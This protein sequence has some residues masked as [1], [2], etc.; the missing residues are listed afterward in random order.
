M[1]DWGELV[2]KQDIEYQGYVRRRDMAMRD[3]QDPKPTPKVDD[4]GFSINY[5]YRAQRD[6]EQYVKALEFYQTWA[7]E[8]AKYGDK[9]SYDKF[10][11]A[12]NQTR[13]QAQKNIDDY[14]AYYDQKRG[15]AEREYGR[16]V[17]QQMQENPA[18]EKYARY[19]NEEFD[20]RRKQAAAYLQYT[21][22]V[23]AD[24]EYNLDHSYENGKYQEAEER[25]NAAKTARDTALQQVT[26]W[27]AATKM[28]DD[29]AEVTRMR[30]M[31][32]TF[33]S[34]PNANM[35]ATEGKA[36]FHM[37]NQQAASE[38]QDAVAAQ[39]YA[40]DMAA[41]GDMGV[42]LGLAN[43]ASTSSSINMEQ[44]GY[45]KVLEKGY[46]TPQEEATF[47]YLWMKNPKEADE[48][49]R[50]MQKLH[51]DEQ[52]QKMA[53]WAGKNEKT[54][55]LAALG[56][57]ASGFVAGA[58]YLSDP[59][60]FEEPMQFFSR[61]GKALTSG[62]AEGLTE[63]GLLNSGFL[64]GTLP[65]N[66]PVIGGKGLG[67]LYQVGV[68]MLQSY[69][70]AQMGMGGAAGAML[71]AGSAAASDYTDMM[72]KG[73]SQEEA[74]LHSACAGIAEGLF[75]EVSLDKLINMDT[76]AG[77]FKNVLTQ[78]GIEASEE[79]CTTLANTVTDEMILGSRSSRQT[80]ARELM[81]SGMSYEEAQ[82]QADR[83][84]LSDTIYD[85]L[86]GALSGAGMT[87]AQYLKVA[88]INAYNKVRSN[89]AK[90]PITNYI[91]EK[92]GEGTAKM[93]AETVAAIQKYAEDN[94]MKFSADDVETVRTW[95]DAQQ[96][97]QQAQVGQTQQAG[98][99]QEAVQLQQAAENGSPAVLAPAAQQ[100]QGTDQTAGRE[101]LA[102]AEGGQTLLGPTETNRN[103]AE[104]NASQ[105]KRQAAGQSAEASNANAEL[106]R[107]E[108]RKARKAE[109]AESQRDAAERRDVQKAARRV[110]QGAQRVIDS[111]S[112]RMEGKSLAEMETEKRSLTKQYGE[113]FGS[114]VDAAIYQQAE[115]RFAQAK[116]LPALQ[117]AHREFS[118]DVKD[119]DIR[120]AVLEAFDNRRSELQR[121][122]A[123]GQQASFRARTAF[124]GNELDLRASY[125]QN[126]KTVQA[127][128]ERF[129]DDGKKVVLS[130]GETV[131]LSQLDMDADAKDIL[132]K[133]AGM[134]L[135]N[136]ASTLFQNFKTYAA[137]NS[138]G[139]TWY[140][141]L[142]G[143]YAAYLYGREN[144]IGRGAVSARVGIDAEAAQRAYDLGREHA[145]LQAEERQKE[146]DRRREEA[147][148]RG[149]GE[150]GRQVAGATEAERREWLKKDGVSEAKRQSINGRRSII[151][152]SAIQGR[153]SELSR[154]DRLQ[155][156]YI[157]NYVSALGVDLVFV[158]ASEY[159][160]KYVG[161]Q[162]S[163]IDGKIV[164]D[165]FAGRNRTSDLQSFMLR[166]LSH[167]L[168]H[169]IEDLSPQ[170]YSE[171]KRDV[172]RV[173]GDKL[174]AD[175]FEELIDQKI[176]RSEK[177]ITRA[178]AES[179]VMAD[180]CEMMLRDSMALDRLY[181]VN[182]TLG[183]RILRW[184][185]DTIT[186]LK[187]WY[188]SNWYGEAVHEEARA[189]QGLETTLR[190][191]FQDRWDDLIVK[192]TMAYGEAGKKNTAGEGGVQF[193]VREE[194][195][196]EFDTWMAK[197]GVKQRRKD[198]GFF[199]LGTT[200]KVLVDI[201]A[202]ENSVRFF[203]SKAQ[204]ILDNHP[205]M[206][207]SVLKNAP[208]IMDDPV[209]VIKSAT[210]DDS[211]TF[212]R[213]DVTSDPSKR[214]F[215]ALSL[216]EKSSIPNI[217]DLY[218]TF[219]S[220]Y[221]R[222]NENIRDL[223]L[224]VKEDKKTG[225][226][227]KSAGEILF[228]S[229]D[230]NRTEALL[231]SLGVQF[232]SE[233]TVLGSLGIIT[234]QDGT[235]NIEGTN[236]YDWQHLTEA[237]YD[238]SG[239]RGN[240]SNPVQNSD[241]DYLDAVKRGEDL[242]VQKMVRDAANKAGFT[243]PMLYHGTD[244]FGFTSIKT[245]KDVKADGF[246]FWAA[247]KESAAGTYTRYGKTRE[248]ESEI[249]YEEEEEA[250]EERSEELDEAIAD[251]R[252]LIDRIFSEWVYGQ[253]GNAEIRSGVDNSNPDPGNGDGVY[254]LL[255]EH[256]ADAFY[257][258]SDEMS[259][260][261]EDF[262]D[263][264]ERSKEWEQIEEAIVDVESAYFAL[265]EIKRSG[266]LGGIYQLYANTDNMYVIDAK[267]AA[268]NELHP[269]G[270]PKIE[271]G[272][273][274]DVPYKTRDVAN[275][276]KDN[277]YDGVIFKNIKDNGQYGRT[278]PF[279]VYAFFNPQAQVKSA[280]P[281]TYDEDGEV[282]PLSERFNRENPD[283]RYSNR[284]A[285]LERAGVAVDTQSESASPSEVRFSERSW[286][287]SRFVQNPEAAAKAL[288]KAL[289]VSEEQAKKYIA[290]I[291]SVA[292]DIAESRTRLDYESAPW[293][294]AFKSNVDYGGTID[295]STL[296][297]KRRLLTGTFSAIQR[298][299]ANTVLT[300]DD[301]L[302]IRNMMKDAGLEV[303]CGMCYVEGSRAKMGEY[304]K[305][306]LELY[307]KYFPDN[308][309]PTMADVN[310]ADGIEWVRQTH[311]ECYEQFERFYNNGGT[312][313]EGDKRAFASQG[314]PK[315]FQARTEYKGEI[316]DAFQNESTVETKN[317]NGGLRMQ[318]F[319][320]FELVH[321]IDCMQV[322]MDMSEVGLAGQAYTKVPEFARALGKTG[323]KI[324]LSLVAEGVDSKGRLIFND[325][326]GM[327]HKTAFDIREEYSDN[328][329]TILVVYDDAQLLAAMA[330]EQID[331]IIPFHRS[332]WKK[333]QYKAMGLPATT[334]DYTYQQNEKWLNPS[335]HT[336][337]YRGREVK[338]KC[339][340]YMP[341]TYWNE[342]LSGKE[343]AENY[344]KMCA[345]DGKRPKFYKLLQNN[346][347]GSYSL[348]A[349][350][351]T[352]GYWKLLIDF[353]M[354]N[355]EGECVPQQPVRPVFEYDDVIKPM[356]DE[357]KG[358]HQQ[359]PVA[360]GIV[361]QF[362]SEYKAANPREQ[363]SERD[364][365]IPTDTELLMQATEA[366][367]ENQEQKALLR[368]FKNK[369]T[370]V[371]ALERRLEKAR[372]EVQALRDE[373]NAWKDKA[374]HNATLG[375][376]M[377]ESKNRDLQ[378]QK[379][380]SEKAL[381]GAL[382]E[383]QAVV[384]DLEKQIQRERDILAG[385][386]K[387][388]AMR[389]LL[390][391]VRENAETK[392]R[393]QKNAQIGRMR[394]QKKSAEL[395]R[396]IGNLRKDLVKRILR[397]TEASFIP[398][399]LSSA[400]V[401]VLELLD[402]SPAEGT[403]AAGKYADMSNRL[404]KLSAVY[405]KLNTEGSIV[406][407]LEYEQEIR[408]RIDELAGVLDGRNVRELT[409]GDLQQVYDITRQI[410]YTIRDA[411]KMIGRN[412]R[413]TVHELGMREIQ[414]Q[415]DIRNRK[416]G[417]NV[418]IRSGNRIGSSVM[419]DALSPM[420]AAHMIG[421]YG[422]S[423]IHG[424]FTDIEDGLGSKDRVIMD[425]NKAMQ[426]LRTG[427][428]EAA[429]MD[430]MWKKRD[431][432]VKDLDGRTVRMTAMQ[433]MQIVMSWQRE[434][435]NDKLVHMEKG[436]AVI[437]DVDAV[438]RGK[439]QKAS[440]TSQHIAVTPEVVA[441][442]ESKLTD[443]DRQYMKAA[444]DVF[445]ELLGQTNEVLYALKH[446]VN[447]GEELY[448]PFAVDGNYLQAQISDGHEFDFLMKANGATAE[449]KT[450]ASQ[451]LII[452]GLEAILNRHINEQ[453]N[454]IGL[455][456]PIRN[457]A[458]V[459]NVR[460]LGTGVEVTTLNNEITKTW[461]DKA[462]GMM[463]EAL[464]NLQ[465][466]GQ[467]GYETMIA[468]AMHGLQ[469][470]FVKA[471]LVGKISVVV[472]QAA[473]FESAGSILSQ[474]AL[475][476]ARANIIE[477][478]LAQDSKHA[479][480]VK[481][482][483]DAR[484]AELWKRRIGMSME[485]IAMNRMSNGTIRRSLQRIGAAME[486][487]AVG[488]TVRSAAQIGD[489]VNWIQR[490]D[491]AT[492][493]ALGIACEYQARM[494]GFKKGTEA[495][496]QHVTDL[497][498]KT[499]RQ[500]QPMYD[501]LHRPMLQQAKKGME[502][503]KAAMPFKTVPFQ[504]MGQ[505]TD[506]AGML[507]EAMRHGTKQDKVKAAK[508]LG[509]TVMA[510]FNSTLV[511][512]GLTAL[513]YGLQH[514]TKRYRDDDDE[515]TEESFWKQYWKDVA[516]V[517]LST[518]LP[519]G[520]SELMD[521]AER[522][523]GKQKWY[524]VI[525]VGS[526][527]LVNT[528]ITSVT[529]LSDAVDAYGAG[530]KTWEDLRKQIT[531]TAM[532]VTKFFGL[533]IANAKDIVEGTI[534][535][536]ENGFFTDAD[537]ERS[538]A[539]NV[540]RYL[541]AWGDMDSDKMNAVLGEMRQ[542]Y[543]DG[544][545]SEK[546]ADKEVMSNLRDEIRS[547]YKAGEL[548]D[549]NVRELMTGLG[550]SA[551]DVKRMLK[552]LYSKM[553]ASGDIDAGRAKMV[554]SRYIGMSDNDIYWEL[555]KWDYT[556]EHKE[557]PDAA[558]WS[559]YRNLKDSL[560]SGRH[561]QEAIDELTEHGKAFN[562]VNSEIKKTVV[563]MFQKGE[564]DEDEA[565]DLLKRYWKNKDGKAYVTPDEDTLFWTLEE[566]GY[567][568]DHQDDDDAASWSNY[569]PLKEAIDANQDISSV[570]KEMKAHG[571][572]DSDINEE[573]K[574]H[575]NEQFKKGVYD[576]NKYKNYLSRYLGI[577]KKEEV[578]ALVNSGRCYKEFGVTPDNIGKAYSDETL[579]KEQTKQAL[580]TYKGMS[581]D[582]AKHRIDAVDFN[583]S[584]KELAWD[585]TAAEDYLFTAPKD[586]ENARTPYPAS[587]KVSAKAI[588]FT[589]EM[590]D[591]YKAAVKE[592]RYKEDKLIAINKLRLTDAQKD[593]LY[594]KEGWAWGDV[595]KT[596]WH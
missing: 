132:G 239:L 535:N 325:R 115:K 463:M 366:D 162:G 368:E 251:Y 356:L 354:Y 565:E 543:I 322:I 36:R 387:P 326:D 355:N 89:A 514:K 405:G 532:Q 163:Y 120:S 587:M 283:I 297:T 82:R 346:G 455:A 513:A 496:E 445:A 192:S 398:A 536:I 538:A 165:I 488:H 167:E 84:W 107:S 133:I 28:R 534:A 29:D 274:K 138:T 559:I 481:E 369:Q 595:G 108:Q 449:L 309:Q 37:Q 144:T 62:A 438:A 473:S 240:N 487:N 533:P 241:R 247:N 276:A 556:K 313:R 114:V 281:V 203:K 72:D 105:V 388:P 168:T 146:V 23:L 68:S 421:G 121:S 221:G 170:L 524:D 118:A 492:T 593:W 493:M 67:D 33:E 155:M 77:F 552:D 5:D 236:V 485:E 489:P 340:N 16:M 560:A 220:S 479:Q 577:V 104:D 26:Q 19:H 308:W 294:S 452:D 246:S 54:R 34:D 503:V 519:Y 394:E 450:K 63:K 231:R 142:T 511:F 250:I 53:E 208:Y 566:M 187:K 490:M 214:T 222:T 306:F 372:A 417:K 353:K 295:F 426:A 440:T 472:K 254:D 127:E 336:H 191:A 592:L 137:S 219:S 226:Q 78:G 454:Y 418:L 87:G 351:S 352:D 253:N 249:G 486:G 263:F 323:L 27:E 389:S 526:L 41:Y 268:W 407:Q 291:N 508:F 319:S 402:M 48:W 265:S 233:H 522:M 157:E 377:V 111:V 501:A 131:A 315:L 184:I 364:Y 363:Y 69:T 574:D 432:G 476:L 468:K 86:S 59:V 301:V 201:G 335:A 561:I 505:M 199:N 293:L 341:N 484:T 384:R 76:S 95:Q 177:E 378:A 235:V 186:K 507:Q 332:Q 569:L 190:Q 312:L 100:Y 594:C 14:K 228:L 413:R 185:K 21:E 362:V 529:T 491:I 469:S 525:S 88:G 153:E 350:G 307:K 465:N 223:V 348:K 444:R 285:E 196:N 126:G 8:A 6:D 169:F 145:Q 480:N 122:R 517:N 181:E 482:R 287:A 292:K 333:S 215:V 338:T 554:L 92:T 300:A 25:Y 436:G 149:D 218:I 416:N 232:P 123:E 101:A 209:M 284:D 443:Y 410:V 439:G 262:A 545:K 437:R 337:E 124:A 582:E 52:F 135:G 156:Q 154:G 318:S 277:G 244:A 506:A 150:K 280:D 17:E 520:G 400:V 10:L 106:S 40:M 20:N 578:D 422:D 557:D 210:R 542:N 205:E 269:E 15:N 242:K 562:N 178:E 160:G 80:R 531:E 434:A 585:V 419:L 189:L 551:D 359:Y 83:E 441:Q 275:W 428:N 590:Y 329:G 470:A 385:K 245:S 119:P 90:R 261:Y 24:A 361:D 31:A 423:V 540:R 386:L 446:R 94:G 376:Q 374:Q 195:A 453:A 564:I 495:Y 541:E 252:Y 462:V 198:G 79:I 317:K 370:K 303:S 44:S 1:P 302:R 435:A 537:V 411:D 152:K 504:N 164:I 314:K 112:A 375:R 139:T 494:D 544:G 46:L 424:L 415:K 9:A 591:E 516:N 96:Q 390:K 224:G 467:G 110:G 47:Y 310:T 460:T 431:Y 523:S 211:V 180:A 57:V 151:D 248:I 73:L 204:T 548:T 547:R 2:R 447:Q 397:P 371:A 305:Q 456:I 527:E 264:Q 158:A 60:G 429:Y 288:A 474:R 466:A 584:H 51:E 91:N 278:E 515:L 339:T 567:N 116:N 45:D 296:C 420:R 42:G 143:F 271:R 113:K 188:G 430:A 194:Y 172:F 328:V 563:E 282:I 212:V 425:S 342:N 459:L 182:P 502:V 399:E 176:S 74:L 141:Y 7:N 349:D 382:K 448:I 260:S 102:P 553:Y 345:K 380:Q 477:F 216:S 539:T 408:D 98:Q 330:D 267:G 568:A 392:I 498:E 464:R 103:A 13:A 357:Y 414:N 360:R 289:K 227:K 575:L 406:T 451:P 58:A 213:E 588:G 596:P 442:I 518:I 93:N 130:N 500:T 200:P 99:S 61:T 225:K 4:R 343:N 148:N 50:Y 75:E 179:E 229:E 555:Q 589:P 304:N 11:R 125:E 22:A 373:K 499:I 365:D 549:E 316:K 129:A 193:A 401:D 571:Y 65:E 259:E 409:S 286:Q 509:K 71:L 272:Q 134:D 255:A 230:K 290:D 43:M 475:A 433:A 128:V 298:A 38:N 56:S 174:G 161:A 207:P 299:L 39:N 256:V 391:T 427:K 321:L 586:K 383:K 358:G 237:P 528:T 147:R 403:K 18:Y 576:E 550:S 173:L 546:E 412:D 279:D 49:A 583:K 270:M 257:G 510:N 217:E 55:F 35:L 32:S 396:R 140:E 579:S 347:D 530:E 580:M 573:I 379:L 324:N 202:H 581:S 497:Y 311:P 3:F 471:S 64:S 258:Y 234:Y 206:S 97:R 238:Y 266:L 171:L 85:G 461:G 334:K 30:E 521:I 570:V 344:L 381:E 66:L 70:A 175:G 183:Q 483:W 558:D 478:F 367:A 166:T 331:F 327:D 458:K 395:K 404:R 136:Y 273:Y 512:A 109:R 243:S 320:D 457:F 572:V 81:A 197:T 12:Y 159:E 117:Q 393:D